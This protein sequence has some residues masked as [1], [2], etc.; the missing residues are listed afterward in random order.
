M[1]PSPFVLING[2]VPPYIA[3]SGQPLVI[4]LANPS[5]V[6]NWQLFV[7]GVDNSNPTPPSITINQTTYT[8]SFNMTGAATALLLRSTVNNGI[9]ST[10]VLNPGLTTTFKT[11]VPDGY[12]NP[13][14]ALGEHLES[15]PFGWLPALNSNRAGGGF[16]ANGD[17]SGSS[18]SQTVV[19][20]N[21]VT[22]PAPSAGVLE[23]V[24][25]ALEWSTVNLASSSYVSGVLPAANQ[26]SQNL[27][28]TGDVS[29][30][31]TT[32][33]TATT[34]ATTGVSAGS[35]GSTT[36]SP[37]ITV[38]A[39][40]R[41]TSASNTTIS[42]VAPS[43]AAGGD[44]SGT[45]PNPTVNKI[46][47][48]S[49]PAP[50]SGVLEYVGGVLEWGAINLASSIY[51]SGVLPSANQASQ[52]LSLTGDISGSGTTAGTTTTLATVNGSPGSFGS[53]TQVPSITVD[54]KGRITAVSNTT[55]S[56]ITPGSSAGGG[57]SGTYPNPTLVKPGLSAA[58][59]TSSGTWTCPANIYTVILQ[60]YGGGGG[61]CGG[62]NGGIS[63]TSIPTPHGADAPFGGAACSLYQLIV[64]VVP[65]TNYP[66]TIGAGGAGG[67][68][69]GAPT[70]PAGYNAGSAGTNT[71]FG[72]LASFGFNTGSF[73]GSPPL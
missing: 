70:G 53:S 28:L 59:F 40:G 42:G 3:T 66:V 21:G 73:A 13:V 68:G 24:G 17:L 58:T 7:I 29:G 30:T 38:D 34:L 49:L 5:G 36:Q 32:A 11:Y 69:G 61:G 71:I 1:L 6:A 43:G 50:A 2:H 51:V 62:T 55:I 26:A 8:A 41:I 33:S 64:N 47:G 54:G 45:Y 9:D 35:Y 18:S 57:L 14:Y 56:A 19:A 4:T 39:K 23:D 48:S 20:L 72:S 31:G 10:G 67:A 63:S 15:G 12:G 65:G 52:N 16:V 46:A 37:V 25:G 22:L 60:G 44:L 27:T